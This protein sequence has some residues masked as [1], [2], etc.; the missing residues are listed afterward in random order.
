MVLIFILAGSPE[1][2]L[3]N[4]VWYYTQHKE[5]VKW[6]QICWETS[7]FLTT[8]GLFCFCSAHWCSPGVCIPPSSFWSVTQSFLWAH[9]ATIPHMK[10][11][12]NTFHM[13]PI[14]IILSSKI[15][16]FQCQSPYKSDSPRISWSVTR[17]PGRGCSPTFVKVATHL[18]KAAAAATV[19]IYGDGLNDHSQV[20]RIL[21]ASWGRSDE[22]QQ[23]QN[24][25]N[26]E[27]E[28]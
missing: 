22:Q 1:C 4:E 8:Q 16:I 12:S 5:T 14:T 17:R 25:P 24:S 7:C 18:M 13:T 20:G 6:H 28:L 3:S 10:E 9:Q 27:M 11:D 23:G 26:L 19:V 2:P 21:K 15:V